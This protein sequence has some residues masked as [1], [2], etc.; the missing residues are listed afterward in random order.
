MLG[1]IR[2]CMMVADGEPRAE[3]YAA[4]AKKGQAG[5]LFQDAVAM[6]DQAPVLRRRVTPTIGKTIPAAGSR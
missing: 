1:G 2:L 5:I 3:I 4:A 6:V